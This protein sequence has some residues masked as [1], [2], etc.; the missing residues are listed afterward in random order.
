MHW[1]MKLVYAQVGDKLRNY[2][3]S[4]GISE[5]ILNY[6][7]TIDVDLS[8]FI[9]YHLTK[10]PSLTLEDIKNISLPQK[11]DPYLDSERRIANKYQDLGS[12]FQKWILVNLRKIRKG[13]FSIDANGNKVMDMSNSLFTR[14]DAHNYELFVSALDNLKDWYRAESPNIDSYSPKSAMDASTEWHNRISSGE[15]VVY[16]PIDPSNIVYG[17]DW[18]N[19]EFSGW[20]IQRVAS[21]NDLEVE[22]NK[23]D[24]CVGSYSDLVERGAANIYSLRDP[25]NNPHA[26]INIDGMYKCIDQVQGKSNSDPKPLYK[27][28]VKEWLSKS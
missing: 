18:D 23:M 5:D 4:I 2:L 7:S 20:T 9:A 27:S 3:V 15:S 26:T 16:D 19:P 14:E 1:Y 25:Q 12:A 28:M 21:K 8:K 6:L 13:T 11:S 22:G 10:N 24:H 17:P